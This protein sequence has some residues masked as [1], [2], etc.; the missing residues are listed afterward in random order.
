MLR[1]IGA[2]PHGA[3]GTV[4]YGRYLKPYEEVLGLMR[5]ELVRKT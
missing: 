1:G 5:R 3:R 4:Y 2:D